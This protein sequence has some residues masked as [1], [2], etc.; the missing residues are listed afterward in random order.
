MTVEVARKTNARC[1]RASIRTSTAAACPCG[2]L[3]VDV[4]VSIGEQPGRSII[5]ASIERALSQESGCRG[6]S[7][8]SANDRRQQER[9]AR[10][11][12]GRI[13]AVAE[14]INAISLPARQR[15]C[16][17]DV[18]RIVDEQAAG[19]VDPQQVHGGDDR[20]QR[21]AGQKP[22]HLRPCFFARYRNC[23]KLS[24]STSAAR[25]CTPPARSSARSRCERSMSCRCRSRLKPSPASAIGSPGPGAI[26]AGPAGAEVL[27]QGRH[28]DAASRIRAPPPAR[29]CSR[30]RGRCRATDTRAAPPSPP[31][32]RRRPSCSSR[33]CTSRGS[34]RRSAECRRRARAAP[35]SR[36]ESR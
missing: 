22:L 3:A 13:G 26:V 31:A 10:R 1:Q 6:S 24:P 14:L 20:D 9:E 7:A 8:T 17:H 4:Q 23:R 35:A 33:A 15:L 28:F 27:R 30:A 32:R 2:S 29:P 5:A 12:A 25:V 19:V 36:P 34:A 11:N 16:Q 21:G 18:V